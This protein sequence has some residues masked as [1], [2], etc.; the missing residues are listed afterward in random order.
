MRFLGSLLI[1]AI[2]TTIFSSFTWKNENL[3][4]VEARVGD[5]IS[6]LLRRYNLHEASCNLEKFCEIN[7]LKKNDPLVLGT[8]YKLPITVQSFDGKSIRSS[9]GLKDYDKALAIQK[10][11]ES[12]AKSSVG[13]KDFRTSKQIWIPFH[14]ISCAEELG[15]KED[16]SEEPTA[17][18]VSIKST[19][20]G[21]VI[22][23]PL[24]GPRY[25]T[26]PVEDFSLANQV[27]Y[28]TSGHGGP[29][30]GAVCT[31]APK[32]MCEDEY[33]YDVALRLARNL[34]Q[35]GAIVHI[36]IQD[37]NDGIR[38]EAY[39]DCDTDERT[40]NG[41]KLPIRQLDRLKQRAD[42]IN[43]LYYKYEKRGVKS[44]KAI[45]IHVDSR[46]QE[47][48]QDVFFYYNSNRKGSKE[49]AHNVKDT[50]QSKY[51]RHQKDRGYHGYIEDRGLYMLR[52]VIPKSV[53]VELAN[54]R[55]LND[56]KRLTI[57]ANR[58]A[59]AN[60]LFEGMIK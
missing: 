21:K 37:G 59:L 52:K 32:M 58:Q 33:A 19:A 16:T 34:M 60:W 1:A 18:E 23:E 42:A 51:A 6:V 15:K 13:H 40:I 24:F 7:G 53:Y 12:M 25:G 36:I 48:S 11:N 8:Q 3:L 45:M 43:R 20:S 50:F 55:N 38:D 56:H 14:L 57:P 26:V 27:F 35:H 22:S 28:I 47:K 2:V 31:S 54:I 10:F 30:P 9:L 4:K 41:N 44:Q 39:L 5:G 49:L 17:G 46:S 29:D